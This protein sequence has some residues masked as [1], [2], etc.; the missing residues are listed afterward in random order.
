MERFGGALAVA[1]REQIEQETA[2]GGDD[3]RANS[4][5]GMAAAR[6]KLGEALIQKSHPSFGCARKIFGV[7]GPVV[8]RQSVNLKKEPDVSLILR[9]L[10]PFP[11]KQEC[12]LERLRLFGG[13]Q[14]QK[15][16]L[17]ALSNALQ[18]F[19]YE[20]FLRAEVVDEQTRAGA[21]GVSQGAQGDIGD[22]LGEEDVDNAFE[23][24][25]LAFAV[26]VHVTHVT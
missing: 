12:A 1:R 25:F 19:R 20:G 9:G 2:E 3:K 10:H 6:R 11:E 22:A 15:F 16:M 8:K 4:F 7:P 24:F 17:H 18:G 13:G 23:E 26:G 21:D 14:L 5:R